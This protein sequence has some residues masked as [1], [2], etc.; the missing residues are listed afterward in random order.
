MRGTGLSDE[1]THSV[2]LPDVAPGESGNVGD[3]VSRTIS[4]PSTRSTLKRA[5]RR[6][7]L[8]LAFSRLLQQCQLASA[9]ELAF[10]GLFL[11]FPVFLGIGAIIWFSTPVEMPLV[12]V[13]LLLTAG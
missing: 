9:E 8:R 6:Y 1:L 3:I 4:E 13:L 5:D 2:S 11:W 12:Q 10:G 7:R